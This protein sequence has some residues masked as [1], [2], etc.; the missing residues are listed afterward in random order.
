MNGEY[1]L[2]IICKCLKFDEK[3]IIN[4]SSVSKYLRRSFW[5]ST[6]D[7]KWK[8]N[9]DYILCI[10]WLVELSNF[11]IPKNLEL[12]L[13]RLEYVFQR[14]H[15]NMDV[16]TWDL[17]LQ[18]KY[19][20]DRAVSDKMNFEMERNYFLNITDSDDDNNSDN[21]SLE[22]YFHATA[23]YDYSNDNN[24]LPRCECFRCDRFNLLEVRKS[25]VKIQKQLRENGYDWCVS[26]NYNVYIYEKA[27]PS[28]PLDYFEEIAL[29]YVEGMDC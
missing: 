14:E 17:D 7:N 6:L 18:H 21:D 3:T 15:I 8:D 29:Q 20:Q 12:D 10:A 25:I 11:D 16:P 4:V 19:Y 9:H 5:S 24:Y 22:D 1:V 27:E 13:S 28:S 2:W 23:G 26:N